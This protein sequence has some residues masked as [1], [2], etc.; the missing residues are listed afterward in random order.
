[1]YKVGTDKYLCEEEGREDR[2]EE[3]GEVEFF[4]EWF[5][6]VIDSRGSSVMRELVF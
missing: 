6:K 1:M 5:C 4:G 3:V 2:L